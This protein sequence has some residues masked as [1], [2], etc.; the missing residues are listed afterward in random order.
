MSDHSESTFPSSEN[1]TFVPE[2]PLET[3]CPKFLL[4]S[5]HLDTLCLVYAKIPDSQKK[6]RFSLKV[7]LFAQT[8]KALKV[9]LSVR[10]NFYI[11]VEKLSSNISQ[12]TSLTNKSF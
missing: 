3:Q 9:T 10:G 6:D 1:A 4:G 12:K 5:G 8:V 7:I 11:I 2:K